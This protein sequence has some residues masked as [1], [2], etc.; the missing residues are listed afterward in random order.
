MSWNGESANDYF[1]KECER[2]SPDK[3]KH[4][5][6]NILYK[7]LHDLKLAYQDLYYNCA[8]KAWSKDELLDFLGS[9]KHSKLLLAGNS[10]ALD[11]EK[12]A[13]VYAEKAAKLKIEIEE[14]KLS[15]A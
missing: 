12:Y 2:Y 10:R 3:Y 11:V 7:S 4:K 5:P 1:I 15:F 14:G 9:V 13:T 6:Q 8:L